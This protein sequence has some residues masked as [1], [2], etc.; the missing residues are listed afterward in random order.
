[1]SIRINFHDLEHFFD[2]LEEKFN[3]DIF[4]VCAAVLVPI[5]QE[6]LD[7]GQSPSGQSFPQ[8]ATS[9][10]PFRAKYGRQTSFRDLF[11]TGGMRNSI[12]LY[13]RTEKSAWITVGNEFQDIALGHITGQLGRNQIA[14]SNFFDL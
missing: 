2:E 8:Y 4:E 11:L 14:P 7:K 3:T 6:N 13:E 5:I 1:M 12:G 10:I 9:Y